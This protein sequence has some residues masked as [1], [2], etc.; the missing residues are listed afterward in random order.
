V[1]RRCYILAICGQ[2]L[3]RNRIESSEG[4]TMSNLSEGLQRDYRIDMGVRTYMGSVG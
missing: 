3:R 1:Q 4:G 2:D